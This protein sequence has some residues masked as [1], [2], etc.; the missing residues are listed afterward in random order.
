MITTNVLPTFAILYVD[1]NITQL[2][3]ILMP[4]LLI[5]VNLQ[6]VVKKKRK[7]AMITMLAHGTCATLMMDVLS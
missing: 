5:L 2:A 6:S 1:V 3:V 7:S 4:V